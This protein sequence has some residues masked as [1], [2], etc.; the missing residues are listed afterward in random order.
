MLVAGPQVLAPPKV[1]TE[2]ETEKN[3]GNG[4]EKHITYPENVTYS[5]FVYFLLIPALVYELE[6]PRTEKI[7]VEYLFEKV[8]T[9]VG[10]FT[11][12][13][14][15][16]DVYI[17]PTLMKSPTES[18]IDVVAELIIPF[19]CCYMLVFYMVF[20]CICNGF[21]E[22]TRFGDRRF[23]N[24]TNFGTFLLV[25]STRLVELYNY[26]R[27]CQKLESSSA[28]LATASHMYES[29][30]CDVYILT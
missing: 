17:A 22:L 18:T 25:M 13:H 21:A 30:R 3:D 20:D 16:V 8:M 15:I 24:G 28:P 12:L 6:Y 14:V 10:I 9:G 7:R 23:Y 19:T 1:E 4:K 5:N 26:G 27:I 2:K 11:V 29:P